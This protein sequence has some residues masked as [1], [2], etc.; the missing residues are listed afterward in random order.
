MP[1]TAFLTLEERGDFVMDDELAH[2]PLRA[3]GWEV[4]DVPWTRPGVDWSGYDVVVIRSPWD[5]HHQPVAFLSTLDEI[6]ARTRLENDVGLVRWN[7][8]KTYLRELQELDVPIVPTVWRD[9]LAPGRLA[10]LHADVGSEEFVVKPVVGAGAEDAWR[11]DAA[12]VEQ[13]GEEV[14][15]LYAGR[16]LQAQ[17]F[18]RSV[19]EEGEWSLIVFGGQLSHTL[20]KTP[21]AG[22]FRVQEEYGSRLAAVEPEASLRAACDTVLDALEAL[23]LYARVDFVRGDDGRWWLMELELI[24]PSLYLRMSEGAPERFAQA[25]HERVRGAAR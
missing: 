13:H 19:V 22:D 15:A 4:E 17:P 23:P 16:P 8:R 12:R 9:G 24:E 3:L 6:S 7:Y 5:Y 2:A 14:E 20:L 21:A 25:L 18:V 11:L 10:A 1:R